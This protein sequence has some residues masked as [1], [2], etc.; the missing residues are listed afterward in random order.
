M[1]Y[2]TKALCLGAGLAMAATLMSAS[3][4]AADAKGTWVR[5][6]GSSRIQISSCGGSLCG[7]LVWLRDKDKKDEK[8]PDASKRSR[9]LLGVQT[10]YGMKP[11]GDDVWKGKVYN[12]EDGKTYSGKMELISANKLK[13]SGCVLGGLI[14]KG[15]TWT[16]VN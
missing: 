7:K 4:F 10:V 14:C 9:S 5:P 2:I 12:A 8:N 16:R 6:S 3:A 11:D 1:T 13:L 15:E